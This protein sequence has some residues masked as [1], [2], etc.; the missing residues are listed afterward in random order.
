MDEPGWELYRTFLGVL[1]AGSLS[2]AARALGLT[3]PTVGRHVDAL[4]TA[5]GLSLFVRTQQGLS[6]TAA[7]HALHPHA[8][9]VANASA[10]LLRA[11]SR[12]GTEVR[13]KVRITASDV[14]TVE[15]LPAILAAAHRS[16]P[17]LVFELSPSNRSEDLL[18]READIAVRMFEPAQQSLIARRIGSIELGVFA[19]QNYLEQRGVPTR[20]D[21]LAGHALIGYDRE[22]A[23][24]RTVKP[25]LPWI[26]RHRFALRTDS[27]LAGLAALRAGFGIGFCQVGIA[28][29]EPALVRLFADEVA[30]TLPTW[31]AMHEDLR[32]SPACRAT[33][34]ALANG[35]ADYLH[36]TPQEPRTRTAAPAARR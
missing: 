6:P 3:Q 21:E 22:T 31:I 12:Q 36:C 1:E 32:D 17:E 11:A 35:L 28:K 27:D 8:R 26:N 4:E 7:A 2:G 34:D 24:I 14:V 20:L 30:L 10:G 16:H 23:F 18:E 33:F 19:H 15:V 29:R 25:Q 5:L 9:A 13:G